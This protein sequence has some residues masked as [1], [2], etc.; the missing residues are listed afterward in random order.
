MID[1][2][3]ITNYN[4]TNSEL[5]EHIL[6]WICAAGK[7]G[8]TSAKCLDRLL[9]YLHGLKKNNSHFGLIRKIH[10]EKKNKK[11]LSPLLKKFGIGCYNSKARAFIELVH[12]GINL[13]T[14]TVEDLENIH[15]IGPKTSRC[16]LIHSRRNV[17]HAGLD[18]HVL[19]Y[20]SDKGYDV[21]AATPS[22]KRYKEIEVIFLKLAKKSGKSVAKFDLDIWN[23]YRKKG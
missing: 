10:S 17:Q 9:T 12:S 19:R 15:S 18:V 1:P 23:E 7:N 3:K 21:P 5:E 14:C 13:K 20:L 6:F 22:K 8:V 4:L 16:F 2:I 11:W